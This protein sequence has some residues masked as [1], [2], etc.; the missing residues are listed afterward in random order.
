MNR[1]IFFRI[2]TVIIFCC[3]G[4]SIYSN[5]FYS[6]FHFDDIPAIVKNSGIRDLN[7]LKAVWNYWP[8][9]F[10]TYLSI[11]VNFHFSRLNVFGYHLFNLA[12]HM[13]SAFMVWWFLTL[14]FSTPVMKKKEISKHSGVIALFGA[15]IFLSHPVQTEAVTY[16]YQRTTSL[17]GFFYLFSLCLYIK[18]RLLQADANRI[19]EAIP[20]LRLGAS[21]WG[22]LYIFSWI[23]AIVSM[24]TKENTATLPLMIVL[25]E[26]CFF[27]R[28]THFNW[29]CTIPFLII[30]LL[31]P[32]LLFSTKPVTFAD[33]QK[34]ISN[35]VS[36]GGYYFLT[37]MRVIVTYIRLLFI[38][39]NQNVDYDYPVVSTA[40]NFHAL[41]GL[42]L[43]FFILVAAIR[44]FHAYRLISFGIFWFFLT[45]LPE[46][47]II[48]LKD[49]IFEHRL[50]L[51]MVGYSLFLVSVLYY[52]FG[53]KT[54]MPVV[55]ILFML[56]G[57]YSMLTYARNSVWRS[58]FA[59]WN[60]TVSKSPQKARPYVNRGLAYAGKGNYDLAISDYTRAISINPD[61]AKAYNNRGSAYGRKKE[62]DRAFSDFNLALEINPDYADA[63]NNR[64]VAYY[65]KKEYDKAWEDFKKA[66]DLGCQIHP[67]FLEL[68]RK[69]CEKDK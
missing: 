59:L 32:V 22:T 4:I 26:F 54:L 3:L 12:I 14:I 30:L 66:R 51:P 42:S 35:P 63:Y 47:S 31:I 53:E 34:L 69:S 67:G 60:D 57:C 6:E 28:D 10:I 37:Q 20:C 41:A 19:G 27:K 18:S 39:L 45:L 61:H 48:P 38:P 16:I 62:Y 55:I 29:K 15:L 58:E 23:I 49:V 33:L 50:Y 5:I 8:T 68:L 1:Q 46:S 11:A 21:K 24:F 13:G 43:L 36:T 25:C 52:R 9:R 44:L 7:N 56:I 17:A 64:A 2:F 65:A 40:L